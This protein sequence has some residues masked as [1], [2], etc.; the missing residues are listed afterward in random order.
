MFGIYV[1]FTPVKAERQKLFGY[2]SQI[3]CSFV[4]RQKSNLS[5]FTQDLWKHDRHIFPFLRHFMDES[6]KKCLSEMLVKK[7]RIPSQWCRCNCGPHKHN[8]LWVPDSCRLFPVGNQA[9]VWTLH[10]SLIHSSLPCV[11][12]PCSADG[13]Y[14]M[15]CGS[16]KSLKLWSVSGGTLLKS[17]SG[18]GYEVLDADG[19]VDFTTSSTGQLFGRC[20]T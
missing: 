20:G 7:W 9:F 13:N 19:W 14:L 2:C 12:S 10:V 8:A 16:D 5:L 11:L 6:L 15:S 4:A 1:I 17:Y 18:H 3:M